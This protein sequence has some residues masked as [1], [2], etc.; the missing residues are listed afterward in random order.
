MIR[1]VGRT[2]L[3]GIAAI[4]A[5]FFLTEFAILGFDLAPLPDK[6]VDGKPAAGVKVASKGH[7]EAKLYFDKTTGLLVKV[8]RQ[9]NEAGIATTKEYVFGSHKD[10]DGVKLATKRT[11]SLGGKKFAEV[12]VAFRF[13]GKVDDALFGKP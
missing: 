9:S 1:R 2:Q 11:E 3:I 12:T 4:L 13:P 8:E 5:L 6:M 10:F 7:M